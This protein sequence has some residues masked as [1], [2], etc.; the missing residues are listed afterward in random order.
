[1]YQVHG[2]R[3]P[4]PFFLYTHVYHVSGTWYQV[5][6]SLPLSLSLYIQICI[7]RCALPPS[8]S[9]CICQ[10]LCISSMDIISI[11][12][13]V[14]IYIYMCISSICVYIYVYTYVY[15]LCHVCTCRYHKYKE[16]V[17]VLSI[18]FVFMS[19]SLHLWCRHVHIWNRRYLDDLYLSL[20]L[21]LYIYIWHMWHMYLYVSISLSIYVYSICDTNNI[22]D[23]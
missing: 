11:C 8:L 13:Y 15:H 6:P 9:I 19:L 4:L 17:F 5:P 7:H 16:N 12:L 20:S 10:Y 22:Y 18:V 21:S 1:M 23:I 2:T 3:W 14:C